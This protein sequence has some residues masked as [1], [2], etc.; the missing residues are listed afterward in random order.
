MKL[1]SLF[2]GSGGF[3][4]AGT[5]CGIEPVWSSE[6][7]PYPLRVTAKRFPNVKQ[8]GDI[9]KINGADIEPVDI[10]SFG[11][12]CQ[13]LS[14]A[15]QMRGIHDGERSKLFFEAVR[16]IK[17]MRDHDKST[18]RSGVDV[19]CRWAIF[20]NVPGAFASNH[21]DDFRCV[22]ESLLHV[23]DERISVPLPKGGKWLDGGAVVAD[24]CSVAW[25]VYDAQ[26]WVPQRRKRI[27]LVADFAGECAG[28]ILFEQKGLS[29]DIEPSIKAWKDFTADASRRFGRGCE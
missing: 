14:Q 9:T 21:G 27:Y 20:E 10:C 5:I 2:D 4:L 11:S 16:I 26:V 13:D 23:A 22:I 25:R 3:P 28:Q 29:G 15:G 8:L 12:P 19:R 6:I 1:G 18:G 7:E 17:E 24:G